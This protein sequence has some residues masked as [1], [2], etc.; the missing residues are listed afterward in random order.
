M[1]GPRPEWLAQ[2]RVA[3]DCAAQC[4]S[5]CL[6]RGYLDCKETTGVIHLTLGMRS[7]DFAKC[8]RRFLLFFLA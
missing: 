7:L 3:I 2:V 5:R 8:P 4:A 1:R 6:R